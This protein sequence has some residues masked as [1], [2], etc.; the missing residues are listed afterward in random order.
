M[1]QVKNPVEGCELRITNFNDY[2]DGRVHGPLYDI[3][4]PC[5]GVTYSYRLY[6]EFQDGTLPEVGVNGVTIEA[7]LAVCVDRLEGFQAGDFANGYNEIAI[8]YIYDAIAIL[9][10]RTTDRKSRGVEG[11]HKV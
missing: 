7:L 9:N 8:G 4:G 5:T 2:E 11:Q 3:E 1:R 6:I 10:K